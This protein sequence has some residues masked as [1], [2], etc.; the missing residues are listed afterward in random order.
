M[1]QGIWRER[2]ASDVI[3]QH[4]NS[5]AGR[6]QCQGGMARNAI[7]LLVRG[8]TDYDAMAGKPSCR[9]AS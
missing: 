6:R 1:K 9:I 7:S 8:P 3:L 5:T 4:P 2:S